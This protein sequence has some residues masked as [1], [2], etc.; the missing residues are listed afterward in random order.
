MSRKSRIEKITLSLSPKQAL[1]THVAGLRQFD[2]LRDY[3]ASIPARGDAV[4]PLQQL[5]EQVER[6]VEETLLEDEDDEIER[7]IR[8]ALRDLGFLYFL[9]EHLNELVANREALL[10]AL[11]A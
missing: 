6:C 5:S 4:H 8:I 1:L 10:T 2:S 3:L 7:A 9:H 11:S